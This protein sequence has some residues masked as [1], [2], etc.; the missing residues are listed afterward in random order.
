[1]ASVRQPGSRRSAPGRFVSASPKAA[2][3]FS[4][5][6]LANLT[7]KRIEGFVAVQ[8]KTNQRRSLRAVVGH[9]PWTTLIGGL[10][11]C[12]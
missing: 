1:L 10:G 6:A 9:L 7:L 3:A 12:G 2:R 5:S 11:C 4:A 8:A